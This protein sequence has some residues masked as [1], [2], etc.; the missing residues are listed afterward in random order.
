MKNKEIIIYRLFEKSDDYTDLNGTNKYFIKYNEMF[1]GCLYENY[2]N[3]SNYKDLESKKDI[4]II[5]INN[6]LHKY[7]DTI[8]DKIINIRLCYTDFLPNIENWEKIEYIDDNILENIISELIKNENILKNND[9]RMLNELMG[10]N[11]YIKND[12]L[13]FLFKYKKI[14]L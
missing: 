9:I 11:S 6:I 12:N 10:E 5:Q 2:I 8:N 3:A 1:T 4:Q 7:I 13:K 14:Y